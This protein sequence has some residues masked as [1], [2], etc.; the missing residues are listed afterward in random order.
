MYLRLS[1]QLNTLSLYLLTSNK[2]VNFA[3]YI[4]FRIEEDANI[5]RKHR[6]NILNIESNEKKCSCRKLENEH[7]P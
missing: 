1:H 4:V 3:V 5:D 7:N 2:R 6:K